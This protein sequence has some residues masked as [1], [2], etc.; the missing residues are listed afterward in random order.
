MYTSYL[1][2]IY[3]LALTTPVGNGVIQMDGTRAAPTWWSL[4]G[5][6]QCLNSKHL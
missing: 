2:E 6:Q 5:D 1:K 3:I 4:R